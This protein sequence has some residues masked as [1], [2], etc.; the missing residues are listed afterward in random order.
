MATVEYSALL[1]AFS[2]GFIIW[3]DIPQP[4]VWLGAGLILL[5]GFVLVVSER[6]EMN[7]PR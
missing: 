5:A 7:A 2:L 1:W 4:S 6:R 3:H